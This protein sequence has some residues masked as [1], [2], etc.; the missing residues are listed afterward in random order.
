M[1]LIFC[2]VVVVIGKVEQ[3]R[4]GVVPVVSGDGIL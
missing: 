3:A 1:V 4:F 2:D